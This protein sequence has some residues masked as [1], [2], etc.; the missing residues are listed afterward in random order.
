M[1]R[2]HPLILFFILL[3]ISSTLAETGSKTVLV[4]SVDGPITQATVE[5][6]K[7]S[8]E[9]AES[10][11]A[12]AMVL[13]IDTPGGGL[14]ETHKIVEMIQQSSVPVVGYVYPRGATAWSA[15]TFILLSTSVAAM[16]N[17][18]VMGSCQPVEITPTGSRLIN[19]SKYI[20][21]LT[22]WI[23]ELADS[24]GKN[25]TI[26]EDFVTKN[27]NLNASSALKYGVVDFVAPS[28]RVLLNEM[29]GT[30]V[31]GKTLYTVGAEVVY[32]SPSVRFHIL[33][34]VSDPTVYSILLMLAI[35]SII[36]GIHT[37][38]HGAE[39]FGVITLILA[40]LGMG[41]S[42]PYV[43]I[44]FLVIGFLLVLIEV[45][46]TP[47]FGFI[48]MGGIISILLGALFLV[49]SYSNMRWLITPGYQQ[50]LIVV[51]VVPTLLI[52][53]F[54]L[55]ALYK[56]MKIRRKKP[57]LNVFEEKEAETLDELSPSKTGYVKY[58]GEYWLAKSVDKKIPA[59]R[60]VV[61]ERREGHVLI[62]SERKESKD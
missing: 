20:N 60:K 38:G 49:P 1:N 36:F 56:V 17:H 33:S 53:A 24:N 7:E 22:E 39:V 5:L 37:P 48:G 52:A 27:L 50:I 43:S 41:F 12:Q 59:H 21:A 19:D 51:A 8:I 55:F 23:K 28:V 45:F 9:H 11:N 34:I 62:V 42:L 13:T 6:V 54:F 40:L 35:F 29:D 25:S 46:I 44:I 31:D 47:G 18:T 3:L 57:V 10:I 14:D 30:V 32:H 16:E 4:T 15:G 61:I 26:A 2:Y 58:R